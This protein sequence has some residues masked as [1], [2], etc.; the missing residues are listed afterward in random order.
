MS[1]QN[2][3]VLITGGSSGI[4]LATAQLFGELGAHVWLVARRRN[5][6]DEALEQVRVSCACAGSAA[7]PAQV[8]GVV[9]ADVADPDDAA[10]AVAEVTAAVG[11]PDIVVNSAGTVYPGYFSDLDLDIFREAME[12][13]YFGTLHVIKALMPGMVS[14]GS[15]H[16]VNICSAAGFM[17]VFGYSA[18][19]ASKYAVRGLSDVLRVELKPHGIQVSVVYPPDTDT[20][21]LHYE[22]TL[23]P[24]ET[25]AFNGGVL[26]SPRQVAQ[27][28]VQGIQHH[29]HTITPGLETSV[30]Y[31]LVGLLRDWQYPIYDRIVHGAQRAK[32]DSQ[33]AHE[34]DRH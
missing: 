11:V 7:A 33:E 6:L 32:R 30:V 21:Q 17:P 24:L 1:F 19:S 28:I 10:R 22:D 14:R 4:G 3:V 27:A 25:R 16:I 23:K 2:R 9:A 13:N 18:Y 20:P 8:C 5:R 29:R 31:R 34:Q 26:L 15:G 12:V